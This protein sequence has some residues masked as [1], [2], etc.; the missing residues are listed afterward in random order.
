[1]YD[2]PFCKLDT[3]DI[4]NTIIEETNNFFILPSKGSLCEGYLLIVPK[5]HIFSMN[6]LNDLEKNELFQLLK[7]YR[8]NF[9]KIYNKYPIFFE[10]G[11]TSVNNNSSS[12]I[13]H[14]HIH[15]VN[16]NFKKQE[17]LIKELNMQKVT[18]NE[19]LKYNNHSYISYITPQ[20]NFYIT[21][22]F[23]P[24]SQQ[25]R[26]FIANDLNLN[27]QYNWRTANF[28]NNIQNTINKFKFNKFN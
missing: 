27:N 25:M 13:S 28:E 17:Q 5:K 11:S 16:H 12:S 7:K 26:I 18:L 8:E 19:F 23:K 20:F 9:Y 10:H 6:E 1:M 22:N 24:I 21:Y 3:N 15:I 4:S 14:A 2:C